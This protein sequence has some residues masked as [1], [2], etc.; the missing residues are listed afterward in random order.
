MYILLALQMT[1]FEPVPILNWTH[2]GYFQ[3]QGACELVAGGMKNM[4]VLSVPFVVCVP[5][6]TPENKKL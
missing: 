5:V 4:K 2:L 3:D 1:L 6:S